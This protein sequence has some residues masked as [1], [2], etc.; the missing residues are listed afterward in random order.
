MKELLLT[1]IVT[2]SYNMLYLK[3][4]LLV[5]EYC[6]SYEL[7]ERESVPAETLVI[8]SEQLC[9]ECGKRKNLRDGHIEPLCECANGAVAE[10]KWET[11]EIPDNF[12]NI[13][14]TNYYPI[15]NGKELN[16]LDW[17]VQSEEK[18]IRLVIAGMC[19][20]NRTSVQDC[21]KAMEALFKSR[22]ATAS[23]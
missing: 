22:V 18:N 9:K 10:V 2:E 3:L 16:K 4:S 6:I 14:V 19:F 8:A 11:T 7:I 13:I 1:K 15:V 23:L 17:Y 21:K 12:G 20:P 5:S